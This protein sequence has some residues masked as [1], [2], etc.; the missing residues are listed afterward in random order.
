MDQPDDA[1]ILSNATALIERYRAEL[2]QLE[3]EM[4]GLKARR[5]CL[6]EVITALVGKPRARRGRPPKVEQPD[7]EVSDAFAEAAA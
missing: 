6:E 4:E 3:I 5:Y 2:Q 7:I 1:S